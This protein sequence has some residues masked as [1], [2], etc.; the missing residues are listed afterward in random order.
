MKN[1]GEYAWRITLYLTYYIHIR[2]YISTTIA[3]VYCNPD[4]T[5]WAICFYFPED[6]WGNVYDKFN[7][8]RATESDF[9]SFFQPGKGHKCLIH[10]S[11]NA[12]YNMRIAYEW[13]VTHFRI[14]CFI[15]FY[16]LCLRLR[17]DFFSFPQ[18]HFIL[19]HKSK[20]LF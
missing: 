16:F 4:I 15:L 8:D 13:Y 12:Y 3:W 11:L 20:F 1:G 5:W 10:N 14:G 19:S 2:I 7:H 18:Y 9:K 6:L 17:T